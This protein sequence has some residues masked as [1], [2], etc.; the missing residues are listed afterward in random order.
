MRQAT[1]YLVFAVGSHRGA[2]PVAQVARITRACSVRPLPGAVPPV[3]GVVAIQGDL[4]PVVSLRPWLGLPAQELGLN[5]Q[6]VVVQV[7][8]QPTVLVVNA[9]AG[10][11]E[12]SPE[13]VV[14]GG[15]MV[16]DLPGVKG[17]V[18]REDEVI[19]LLDLAAVLTPAARPAARALAREIP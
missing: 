12:C 19:L 11:L 13:A 4:L 3:L 17:V 2:L 7:A 10:L 18:Q 5:D 9:V 15:T 6:F 8:G 14:P 1:P 16:G